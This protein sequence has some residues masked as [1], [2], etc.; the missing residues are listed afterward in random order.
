MSL[1]LLLNP[2]NIKN[3]EDWKMNSSWSHKKEKD[4]GQTTAPNNRETESLIIADSSSEIATWS[5]TG[6]KNLNYNWE[7]LEAQHGQFWKLTPGAL[8]HRGVPTKLWGLLQVPIVIIW[9]KSSWVS[10]RGEV[11]KPFEIGPHSRETS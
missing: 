9:E 6:K 10:S 1:E 5:S 8:S 3:W 4:T 7:F 11:K 2:N